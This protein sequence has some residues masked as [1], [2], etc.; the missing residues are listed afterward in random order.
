MARSLLSVVVSATTTRPVAS[1]HTGHRARLRS[2]LLALVVLFGLSGAMPALAEAKIGVVDL[3]KVLTTTNAGKAAR[4]KFE[5]LQKSK[6]GTLER[7]EK[8]LAGLEKELVSQRQQIEKE[9]QASG[10]NPSEELRAKIAAFQEKARK[11]E[12]QMMELEKKRREIMEDLTRKEAELLKPIEQTIKTKVDAIA[13]ERGLDV[14]LDKRFAIYASD[15]T[16][17]TAEVIR[18]CDTP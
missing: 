7:K 9:A 11:F 12:Q 13:K 2:L 15:A 1:L 10:G 4:K 3:Q 8:E 17:V 5:D 14:V 18:R 6:Q 16:D